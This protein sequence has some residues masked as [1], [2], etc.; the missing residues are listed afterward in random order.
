M[1]CV[2]YENAA[3][4]PTVC[5]CIYWLHAIE[6]YAEMLSTATSYYVNIDCSI[7]F[8]EKTKNQHSSVITLCAMYTDKNILAI[9]HRIDVPVAFS[10]A[11]ENL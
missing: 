7:C 1:M 8:F 3:V 10:F 11:T 2:Y 9:F 4:T 5:T 6:V